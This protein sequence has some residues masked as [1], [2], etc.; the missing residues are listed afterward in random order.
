M[1]QA[2]NVKLESSYNIK[3]QQ[4]NNH[5]DLMWMHRWKQCSRFRSYT[6]VERPEVRFMASVVLESAPQPV[7]LDDSGR[8]VIDGSFGEG[9]GQIIRNAIAYANILRKEV[10]IRNIRLNRRPKPGLQGQHLCGIRLATAICGGT[11]FGDCSNSLEVIYQPKD[12][13]D[14]VDETTARNLV[15]ELRTAGSICLILQAALPCALFS[16]TPVHLKLVGGG[17]NATM[18]PQYEYWS[19]LF[20]PTIE[21]HCKLKPDQVNARVIRRGYYPKG[22]GLVTVEVKPID[23]CLHPLTLIYRGKLK[24]I[25]IRAFYTEDIKDSYARR[26]AAEAKNYLRS[27]MQVNLYENSIEEDQNA[28]G[29]GAGIL[30]IAIFDTGRQLAGSAIAKYHKEKAK[31]V[32]MRA[33]EELFQAYSDGGCVDEWLQDQLI[34][35]AALADGV[36][37]IATGSLTL[38]TH[39]AIMLAEKM[40]GARFE[41]SK[42]DHFGT[43][44]AAAY[45]SEDYG[46]KGR[47][48]GKHLIRC[49]GIGFQRTPFVPKQPIE[50]SDLENSMP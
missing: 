32:A 46:K 27:R 5:S 10:R 47:I 1:S 19:K 42:L 12:I 15:G 50:S 40:T 2:L 38:H 16:P 9:G 45:N 23:S 3:L 36:S 37:Q 20:L 25:F 28:V 13:D 33:A 43:A 30:I 48:P 49:H 22:G 18:A 8:I 6:S 41:I 34:L 21:D 29:S 31:Y 17:T 7:N 35:Y 11:L 4:H 44:S 24:K 26:M 14:F 39:T